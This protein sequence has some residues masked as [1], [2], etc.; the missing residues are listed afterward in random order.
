MTAD[1]HSNSDVP[2]SVTGRDEDDDSHP[3]GDPLAGPV[4]APDEPER[5]IPSPL[6]FSE[7]SSQTQT[8]KHA[9]NEIVH[10][11]KSFFKIPFGPVGKAFVGELARQLS[12]AVAAPNDPTA[13]NNF[14][15]MPALLLQS[16]R[17]GS[18]VK[19]NIEAQ[20]RL[21]LWSSKPAGAD[22][23]AAAC[24]MT[25]E[26]EGAAGGGVTLTRPGTSEL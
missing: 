14:F 24:K 8:A 15:I 6:L 12:A 1:A 16:T 7:S 13:V 17:K 11:K 3:M 23:K 5:M 2:R 26:L 9:Y 4:T 20:R 19:E 25:S 21:H 10:W 18:K 22:C